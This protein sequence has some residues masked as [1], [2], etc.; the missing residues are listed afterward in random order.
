MDQ[1]VFKIDRGSEFSFTEE[2]YPSPA[3]PEIRDY[4]ESEIWQN[5]TEACR[6]I[7]LDKKKKG[8]YPWPFISSQE[9]LRVPLFF[10]NEYFKTKTKSNVDLKENRFLNSSYHS[11]LQKRMLNPLFTNRTRESALTT[12][13]YMIQKLGDFVFFAIKDN[14]LIAFVRYFDPNWTNDWTRQ[15]V[16][17]EKPIFANW[18]K[19]ME[20]VTDKTIDD[21]DHWRPEGCAAWIRQTNIPGYK[22]FFIFMNYFLTLCDKRKVPDCIG[23]LNLYEHPMIHASGK[24]PFPHFYMPDD[25]VNFPPSIF[26]IMSTMHKTEYI[27]LIIP[28]M[29]QWE[30]A[31]KLFYPTYCRTAYERPKNAPSFPWNEKINT[32]LFRGSVSGCFSDDRNPRIKLV[33]IS[34]KWSKDP[35]FNQ[36][37]PIDHVPYLDAKFIRVSPWDSVECYYKDGSPDIDCD[38]DGYAR[39]NIHPKQ[40]QGLANKSAYIPQWKQP[41]YKYLLS[42]E[43]SVAPWREPFLLDSGSTMIRANTPYQMWYTHLLK[44]MGHYIPLDRKLDKLAETIAWC[45]THDDVCKKISEN[46]KKFYNDYLN[47]EASLDLLQ[48][49]ITELAGL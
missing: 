15:I 2:T 30:Y 31:S 14:K 47:K 40:L 33:K 48:L 13:A 8:F 19:E 26:P 37:N 49:I 16:T 18:K 9:E 7:S 12:L 24:E 35:N 44:P 3:D 10:I 46:A 1:S 23:F 21:R 32:L 25:E 20:I 28:V 6:R 39:I 17:T 5:T 4:L 22:G 43:G 45:K 11:L 41:K 34:R 27:D 36:K 38:G 29:D 42:V